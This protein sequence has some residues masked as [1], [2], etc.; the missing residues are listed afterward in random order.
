LPI[1]WRLYLPEVWAEDEERRQAVGIPEEIRFQTKPEVAL[2]QIRAAVER[3]MATAPLLADSAYG[4]DTEFREGITELGLLYMVGIKSS[5]TVWQ[6]GQGPLPKRAAR[7][8]RGRPPKFLRRDQSHSPV[9]V[10]DLA[11]A[12]PAAAWKK[13]SW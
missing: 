11:V 12:L 6:P 3:E 9:A 10:K 7:K 1:A 8:G 4:T 2:E 5:V 13:I